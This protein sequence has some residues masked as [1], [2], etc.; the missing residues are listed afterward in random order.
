MATIKVPKDT[1]ADYD[2]IAFSFNNKHSFEDF[3]IYRTSDGD[4]YTEELQ[5]TISDKTAEVNGADGMYFFNSHHKQKVF[6]ISF[7][8]KDLDDVGIRNMK[9][10][11]N[12]KEVAPLWFAENPYKVYMA[13]V[14]GQPSIK[15]IPFDEKKGNDTV[16]VYRGEGNVQFTAYWPYAQT[17]EMVYTSGGAKIGDGKLS[18]SYND[19]STNN[20][21]LNTSELDDSYCTIDASNNKITELQNHG[22]LPAPFVVEKSGTFSGDIEVGNTKITVGTVYNLIWD[23]KTG[24][25]SGTDSSGNN[26]KAVSFTGTSTGVIPVGGATAVKNIKNGEIK[27]SYW[28]Y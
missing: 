4:R 27:Y 6:N 7:A 28:Y 11:L 26:R 22:D 15:Y 25:V 12:G 24:M 20:Q 16:R 9:N 21:W 1:T 13:K 5:P 17:P 8:F 3:G 23:S 14:T 10:W 19:F 18:T 2:Y